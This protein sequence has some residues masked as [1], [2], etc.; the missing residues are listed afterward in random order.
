MAATHRPSSTSPEPGSSP[1]LNRAQ[2]AAQASGTREIESTDYAYKSGAASPRRSPMSTMTRTDSGDAS[3]DTSEAGS[4]G[5]S[6]SGTPLMGS[7]GNSTVSS[8]STARR[9]SLTGR[10][11]SKATRPVLRATKTAGTL[12]TTTGSQSSA[13]AARRTTSHTEKPSDFPWGFPRS[14]TG[15]GSATSAAYPDML[16][17]DESISRQALDYSVGG[18]ERIFP[19]RSIIND[20]TLSSPPIQTASIKSPVLGGQPLKSARSESASNASAWV[21]GQRNSTANAARRGPGSTYSSHSH[22]S[23]RE[24][25]SPGESSQPTRQ[26]TSAADPLSSVTSMADT[27]NDDDDDLHGDP[28][29]RRGRGVQLQGGSVV[30]GTDMP[31]GGD[32]MQRARLSR[33]L[34]ES[35]AGPSQPYMTVRFEHIETADG[36]MVVTGREGQIATCEDEPIHIPGS[37]QSYGV[38]IAFEDDGEGNLIVKQVSE[39]VGHLLGLPAHHLFDLKSFTEVLDEDQEEVLR[40]NMEMLEDRTTDDLIDTGPHTFQLSGSGAIGSGPDDGD[41][42]LEWDCWAALHIPSPDTRP[43]LYILELEL[44]ND[45]DNPLMTE[46]DELPTDAERGGLAGEPYEPTKEDLIQSTTNICKPL[47]SLVRFKKSKTASRMASVDILK[48]LTQINDQ[49]DKAHDLETFLKLAIGVVKEITGFHRVM[50]YQFDNQWNGQVVAELVDWTR[51]RDLYRGLHF[52]ASDI[53]AQARELYRINKVR[54]LYDRDQPTARLVCCS[55]AELDFPLDMTHSHLRAMSPIHLRYLANMGVRAS[56]SI[57]IIAFGALWGLIACHTYGRYGQRV[58]FPV[59][60]LCRILGNGISRNL[61]RL[62]YAQRLHSR[63]LINTAPSAANPGGYIVAKAEDLLSLFDAD[64]GLLS[65]G[66]EAKILGPLSNSQE[67]LAILEYLKRRCFLSM[68]VSQD[69]TSDF[70]DIHYPAGF[71]IISGMLVVPLTSG[72]KDFITFFRQGQLKHVHWAGNPYEKVNQEGAHAHLEPRK[73]F[74]MWSETVRGQCRAW[75]D[76]QLETA[77][78]LCLVYGKFI[79][80]W[81]EKQAAV[82]TSQLT[83]LLLSNASHEV[84]TPL[85]HIL[86]YLEMALDG[87]LEADTKDHLTKSYDASRTLVHVINDLLDLTRTEQGNA[88][89]LQEPMDLRS[90][91]QDA[92]GVHKKEAE[93]RGL[94]FKIAEIGP[95]I[96]STVLGDR[97]RVKQIVGNVAANAVKHTSEGEVTIELSVLE[98]E[99]E[100]QSMRSSSKSS[101]AE[102]HE[103]GENSE[104]SSSLV[105][106]MLL[107]P[108]GPEAGSSASAGSMKIS[109]T[110]TDTG[111][112]IAPDKLETIFR[113]FEEVSPVEPTPSEEQGMEPH[114]RPAGVGLGLAVVARI[115]NTLDGQLRVESKVEKGSRFTI[116]LPFTRAIGGTTQPG[117]SALSN[118]SRGPPRKKSLGS[119]GSQA[120]GASEIDSIVEAMATSHLDSPHQKPPS[121]PSLQRGFDGTGIFQSFNAGAQ[122]TRPRQPSSMI[123]IDRGAEGP[124]AHVSVEDSSMPLRALRVDE[125]EVS[126]SVDVKGRQTGFQSSP[127]LRDSSA[128]MAGNQII[129]ADRRDSATTTISTGSVTSPERLRVL[130]VDDDLVNRM[131]LF[132]QLGKDGHEVVLTVHGKDG[133]DKLREDY[134]FDVIIMDLQMPI[135]D[136]R[137]ATR[138][139]RVLE[140]SGDLKLVS[141]RVS[142]SGNGGRIPIIAFSASLPERDR[143]EIADTGFDGWILKP[144][145]LARLRSLFLGLSD[146]HIRRKDVYRPGR[147]E[148]GGWLASSTVAN[149]ASDPVDVSP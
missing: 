19:I 97:A 103:A 9:S 136:G 87:P 108:P 62:S 118:S 58:S 1:T 29:E 32:I 90:T 149:Q 21:Q 116:I 43:N 10:P 27:R 79:S 93:R 12:E 68:Q 126:S 47:K 111:C 74:K 78:V 86:N 117:S 23:N 25:E 83:N 112:G 123:P 54:S 70:P 76:E 57:S 52:P 60:Q 2:A 122:A 102:S 88:L 138:Q 100:S 101:Q 109:I 147:W 105:A 51:T 114:K 56:T 106:G 59:R 42:K 131:I 31:A 61:E 38:L 84:R 113:E 96:P 44:D 135:I 22:L 127:I 85:N 99:S 50:I 128:Q 71:Q 120:S 107:P 119:A 3:P 24:L 37:I 49:L 148:R 64:F 15:D 144:L 130:V 137:E 16:Q 4:R 115:I 39:N 55:K 124:G 36:H 125:N 33:E 20:P 11:L 41:N 45:V 140:K 40:E 98:R 80:V 65:I 110:I 82:Q 133:L 139:I 14:A 104:T 141:S 30:S 142:H 18:S 13:S 66:G 34:G 89:F 6:Q 121:S 72:G 28:D 146:S 129:S 77:S 95:R 75:T 8:S 132:R 5:F 145:N 26:R 17:S 48:V 81:R 69:I 35:E 73:S 91:I 63:K 92:V 67:V 134:A 7:Q 143:K 53:P 94:E 46:L